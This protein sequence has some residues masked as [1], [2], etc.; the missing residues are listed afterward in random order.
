[1]CSLDRSF[2]GVNFLSNPREGKRIIL[3]S[4]VRLVVTP[5]IFYRKHQVQALTDVTLHPIIS[6]NQ[7]NYIL[8]IRLMFSVHKGCII[9]VIAFELPR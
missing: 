8:N 3:L 1:M 6:Q 7:T 4:L 9:T 2:Y 5:Q